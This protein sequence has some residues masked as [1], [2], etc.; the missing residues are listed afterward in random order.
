M[1]PRHAH[2]IA[3]AG[4]RYSVGYSL[5][6]GARF[7]IRVADSAEST[8]TR[9]TLTPRLSEALDALGQTRAHVHSPED[10]ASVDTA[11]LAIHFILESGQ[12]HFFENFLD[13]ADS[14]TLPHSLCSFGSRQEADTWL[15]AH[16][17]PPHG[18]QVEI[19]GERYSVGY[20]RDSEI[21]VLVRL[22]S[23]EELDLAE[24]SEEHGE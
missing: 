12:S 3:I 20:S 19:A 22:P 16:P 13:N 5:E 14:K 7:L 8:T 2:C 10:K 11:L 15:R 1:D 6:R 23:R 18:A 21:R 4:H 9:Q 17:R 24:Q